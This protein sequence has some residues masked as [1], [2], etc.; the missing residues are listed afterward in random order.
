MKDYLLFDLDGTLTDPKI[1]ITTCV[2]Y[3]LH[4]MGIEEP[5]LDRLEPFIGPPLR[6]S[7]MQFYGMDEAQAQEAVAKYRERFQD[8]GIFENEI[9]PGTDRMLARLRAE[10]LHLA[11]ASSKPTVFVKRILEHFHISQYFEVVVGSE[12]DGTRSNKS[13]VVQE[14]LRQLFYGEK[15]QTDRVYMIGDTKYDVEGAH[16]W[17]IESVGVAYGYGGME[18]LKAAKSDYIVTSV[19]QLENFLL[20]TLKEK[21]E[22]TGVPEKVWRVLYLLLLFYVVRVLAVF[23]VS[24]LLDLFGK[25]GLLGRILPG[26]LAGMFVTMEQGAVTGYTD[27]GAVVVSIIA[28]SLG[29][30]AVLGKVRKLIAATWED[31][32]LSHLRPE[33]KSNYVLLAGATVGSVL[34][35]NLL[36][37]LSG[38]LG[39]SGAYN[40]F[41]QSNAGVSFL[42]GLVCYGVVTPVAEELVFRGGIYNYLRHYTAVLPAIVISAL[43]FGVYH[44]NPVQGI[45]A[46]VMGC[47]MAYGYE[48]FGSFLVPVAIHVLAN[49]LAWVVPISTVSGT[50]GWMTCVLCLL[51]GGLCVWGLHRQKNVW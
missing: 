21:E 39:V 37:R 45:Y 18:E 26:Q 19:A 44:M 41:A 2:Q 14:A 30:L 23:G 28:Y 17:S 40:A 27:N 22:Q 7:F 31:V 5:D 42:L 36:F 1:G 3:A 47:L 16:A 34:G 8:V 9:Y 48:Y 10:G 46:F 13:E 24:L 51:V 4:S 35:V 12:L 6:D 29:G 49:L 43:I 15:V 33:P 20:R 32:K 25:F 38:M 11:V 50:A